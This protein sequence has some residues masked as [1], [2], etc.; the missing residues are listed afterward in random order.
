MSGLL[1]EIEVGE[2]TWEVLESVGRA[3]EATVTV[4][5][6]VGR[7]ERWKGVVGGVV[8]RCWVRLGEGE[9][10]EGRREGV[11]E[12]LRGVVGAMGEEEAREVWRKLG[13]EGEGKGK[14]KGVEVV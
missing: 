1:G 4:A 9:G 3:L 13:M 2:G 6:E 5:K 8:G 14:G 10:E 7:V 12:V 11:R